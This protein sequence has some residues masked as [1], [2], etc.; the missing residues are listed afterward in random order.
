MVDLSLSGCSTGPFSRNLAPS[1]LRPVKVLR[2]GF[3]KMEMWSLARKKESTNSRPASSGVASSLALNRITFPPLASALTKSAFLGLG[4][5]GLITVCIESS[6]VPHPRYFGTLRRNS[7]CSLDSGG[8]ASGWCSPCLSIQSRVYWSQSRIRKS[9]WYTW[10]T[11]PM[12]SSDQCQ[13]ACGF[14]LRSS[15]VSITWRGR[16]LRRGLRFSSEFQGSRPS[17]RVCTSRISTVSST[18]K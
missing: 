7:C 17:L 16:P 4:A 13:R 15:S 5:I 8:I 6:G 10:I 14:F 2:V 3:S 18:R 9:R 12:E 11:V 1:A